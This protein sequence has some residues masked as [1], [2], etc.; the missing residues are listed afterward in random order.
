MQQAR[1]FLALCEEQGFTRAARRCGVS[2][3]SLSLAIRE[4]ERSLGGKLF[5][6][7]QRGALTELGRAVRPHLKK[8]V[9]AAD[10]A[11]QQAVKLNGSASRA[12]IQKQG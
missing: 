4:L 12:R 10:V 11:H 6:R 7:R 9:R 3:P 1:Y 8:I 2:Q 5:E